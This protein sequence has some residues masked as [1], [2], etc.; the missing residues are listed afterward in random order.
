MRGLMVAL[1]MA[2]SGAAMAMPEYPYPGI[3]NSDIYQFA[4]R[5]DGN[6]VAWFA[7]QSAGYTS[8]LGLM[9]NG[10]STGITGLNNHAS[11]L[12]TALDFGPV[13]AG[14]RLGFYIDVLTT[15]D[16]FYSDPGR[17]SDG[18]Q[19]VWSAPF[20]GG[21]F[22]IP[23]GVFIGFEDLRDGGDRDYNDLSF[24]FTNVGGNNAVPEPA[25]WMLLI[26][27]FGLVGLAARRRR[28][29]QTSLS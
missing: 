19:H 5:H 4:A 16:R 2:G 27:G 25:T 1:M 17:N 29:Q 22:D 20:A 12:G 14:D 13:R 9:V 15:G 7:G 10:T 3:A 18:L 26:A 6:V 24:V 23:K 28:R 11:A 21:P 8:V